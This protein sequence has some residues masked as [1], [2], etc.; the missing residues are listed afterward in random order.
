MLGIKNDQFFW[1]DGQELHMSGLM[2][3]SDDHVVANNDGSNEQISYD[4]RVQG[5]ELLTRDEGGVVRI[6]WRYQPTPLLY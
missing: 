6:F 1:T 3:V 5:N 4:Y 2:N